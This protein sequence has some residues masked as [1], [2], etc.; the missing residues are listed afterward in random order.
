MIEEEDDNEILEKGISWKSVLKHLLIIATILL[1]ALLIYMGNTPDT[2]MNV[3]FGFILICVAATAMQINKTP[4]EPIKQT[5]TILICKLCGLVKV[6]NYAQ[7]D[8]VFRKI[9]KCN[10]CN[11]SMEINQIYS[12]RLKRPTEQAQE[13]EQKKGESPDKGEKPIKD[14]QNKLMV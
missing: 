12:V 6:R 7:G 10:E 3:F 8:F 5:L 13:E 2:S 9:G 1:G 4:P 14:L 11:K